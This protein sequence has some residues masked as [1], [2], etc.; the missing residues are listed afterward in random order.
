M[1]SQKNKW[2]QWFGIGSI[3]PLLTI[4]GAGLALTLSWIGILNFTTSESIVIGLIALLA[5]DALTERLTILKR[6]EEK[7]DKKFETSF[8]KKRTELEKTNLFAKDA[9]EFYVVA[10][11]A[12]NLFSTY[13]GFF[14][15]KVKAGLKLRALI[16]DPK[17]DAIKVWSKV[18]K[19]SDNESRIDSAIAMM[20]IISQSS[21]Q[22]QCEVRLNNSFVP[23]SAVYVKLPDDEKMIVEY[24][25]YKMAVDS[26]PHVILS[27]KENEYWFSYYYNQIE[28]AWK[29][30]EKNKIELK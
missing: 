8:L 9:L 20:K 18:S 4:I 2:K 22:N 7:I 5:I 11:H 10:I 15:E 16:L 12:G 13:L 27:K 26:K 17:G 29:D 14:E 24:Y 1:K 6:I 21:T 30:S 25:P 3:I 23:Y 28:N 19:Y